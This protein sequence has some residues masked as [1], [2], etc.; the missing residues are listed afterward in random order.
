M[1]T[2]SSLLHYLNIHSAIDG[3]KIAKRLSR[4]INKETNTAKK[5]LQEYNIA[6]SVVNDAHVAFSTGEILCLDSDFWQPT[7]S[8]SSKL[9]WST[10]KEITSAYLL[11]KRTG[12]E[13]SLLSEEAERVLM[14]CRQQKELLARQIHHTRSSKDQYSKGLISLLLRKL[15]D[16]ES[17]H[18]KAVATFAKV[19]G[20]LTSSETIPSTCSDYESDSDD[21][22]DYIEEKYDLL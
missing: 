14:Y 12:E 20:L 2:D 15:A 1:Q 9:P 17:Y 4:S 7:V 19:D 21:D 6:S 8:S 22:S 5:L 11:M 18:S 13:L 16:V 10:Q 3:Q